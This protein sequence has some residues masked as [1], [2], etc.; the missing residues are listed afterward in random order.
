MASVEHLLFRRFLFVCL[1]AFFTCLSACLLMT[2]F[3]NLIWGCLLCLLAVLVAMLLA[4]LCGI[5]VGGFGYEPGANFLV[6]LLMTLLSL[7][8]I[9][10]YHLSCKVI[11]GNLMVVY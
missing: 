10:S 5:F 8:L 6:I 2:L 3:T 9:I 7:W 4:S 1:F 11:S